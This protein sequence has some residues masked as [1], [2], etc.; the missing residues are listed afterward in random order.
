MVEFAKGQTVTSQSPTVQVDNKLT[1]GTYTFSLVVVN[2][3]NSESAPALLRV[4][5]RSLFGPLGPRVRLPLTPEMNL[6]L[7]RSDIGVP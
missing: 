3:S 7:R 2:N 5:V 4:I 1:A 6:N